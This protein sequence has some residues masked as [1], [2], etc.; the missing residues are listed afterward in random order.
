MQEMLR[1]KKKKK[2][3]I[4]SVK[5]YLCLISFTWREVV[6]DQAEACSGTQSWVGR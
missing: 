5:N 2:V 3:M 6:T 1:Q 4:S